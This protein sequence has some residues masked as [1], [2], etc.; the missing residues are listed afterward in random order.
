MKTVLA[1]VTRRCTRPSSTPWACWVCLGYWGQP[2]SSWPSFVQVCDPLVGSCS[3][4]CARDH[5]NGHT[6]AATGTRTRG[7]RGGGGRSRPVT[8]ESLQEN[9]VRTI[10][11]C[12]VEK[13]VSGDVECCCDVSLTHE[14]PALARSG[15]SRTIKFP[16]SFNLLTFHFLGL[17]K[18]NF[19]VSSSLVVCSRG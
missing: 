12:D 19:L 11:I 3:C 6:D 17:K 8:Q 10:Y 7:K 18:S 9:V 5:H 14:N 15:A 16:L 4:C 13:N 2:M 1:H